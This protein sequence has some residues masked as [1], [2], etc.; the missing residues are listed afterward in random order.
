MK[1]ILTGFDKPYHELTLLDFQ[2]K[3]SDEKACEDYLVEM[4]W[5]SQ[6]KCPSGCDGKI[7]KV[8][9]C[10]SYVF[11]CRMCKRQTSPTSGT[12]FHKSHIPL[13]KWFWA[14]FL[15]ATSKK[16][17][18]MLYLQK[19]LGIKS[20]RTAW[21]MGHK[22]RHAMLS[23]DALYTL[24]GTVQ[25]D[26]IFIGGK[27]SKQQHKMVGTNKTP[28]LI[29]V[30]ESKYQKPRFVTFEELD[31]VYDQ[32]ILNAIEKNI[33]KGSTIKSDGA[34]AYTK[35][36]KKGYK[37]SRSVYSKNPEVTGEHLKWVNILTSNL[38]RFLLSTYQGVPLKYHKIY[39]AEFAYRFNRRYWPHQAFDRLLFACIHTDPVTLPDISA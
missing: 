30:E 15:M 37:H 33:T 20:Y 13:L 31:T 24:N 10:R 26:E 22:I 5:L 39:L 21:L 32:S 18:S 3:F 34:T 8:S 16:G 17:I 36:E 6:P 4:R 27:Q 38:K 9:K 19:Q 25:A 28:F 29:G 1:D 35:A 23:R 2:S 11:E 7:D 12:I 14:I